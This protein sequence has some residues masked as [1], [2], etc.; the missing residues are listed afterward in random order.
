MLSGLDSAHSVT[1]A[2][3]DSLKLDL[4]E[5][6]VEHVVPMKR[7][8]IEIVDPS[9]ADPRSNSSSTAIANG[10]ATSPST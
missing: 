9:E 6:V 10:P 8:V 1:F 4:V 5:R 3:P 2:T 7:I